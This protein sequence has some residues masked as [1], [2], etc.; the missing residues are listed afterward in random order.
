M[1]TSPDFKVLKEKKIDEETTLKVTKN[2]MSGRIF[3][4]FISV[5]PRI[6]LQ[7]NFQDSRLGK[8]ESE[9]FSKSITSTDQLR[10]YFG[11]EKKEK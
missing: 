6:V 10:E 2:L 9:E 3:V 1:P 8:R 4:E 11:L 7:K 5:D